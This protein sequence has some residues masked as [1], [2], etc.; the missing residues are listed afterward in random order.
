ME[1]GCLNLVVWL[2]NVFI[3]FSG[4]MAPEYAMH[5]QF[6]TKSDVY[7][8]GVI[9]LEI[10]SG[11]R[12]SGSNQSNFGDNL[13]GCVRLCSLHLVWSDFSSLWSG[14]VW[15]IVWMLYVSVFLHFLVWSGLIFLVWSSLNVL[16]ECFFPFWSGLVLWSD[17]S[18][19]I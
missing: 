3:Y 5:G 18:G 10:V 14:Q 2:H 16:C 11:K 12:I 19:L 1:Y 13:L 9:I 8:F 15:Y 4:Y 17:F 7:S 6:S